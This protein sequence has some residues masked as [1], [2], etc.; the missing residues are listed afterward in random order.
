[1]EQV[2]RGVRSEGEGRAAWLPLGSDLFRG[3]LHG[4]LCTLL[5]LD[6]PT[7]VV[8]WEEAPGWFISLIQ[9]LNGGRV[10]GS[11]SWTTVCFC[12]LAVVLITPNR[13]SSWRGGLLQTLSLILASV[14]ASGLVRVGVVAAFARSP[15][16]LVDIP[17]TGV[18]LILLIIG[19]FWFGVA[20]VIQ[21]RA[22]LN[23]A[24]ASSEP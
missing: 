17:A 15:M 13:W 4:V 11:L 16:P 5:F 18:S 20:S 7:V 2:G 9:F 23:L 3:G 19:L 1:M 14:I 10:S 6:A 22:Q 12:A 8:M 24:R 21:R